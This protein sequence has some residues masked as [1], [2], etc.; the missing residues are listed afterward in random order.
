[1]K[2]FYEVLRV[3]TNASQEQIKR[4]FI[5][6]VS[7]YHPDVYKGDKLYA[8]RYTA[9]ITEAYSVL[10]DP[11]KRL[12]Y[13]LRHN[14]NQKP[15]RSQL[16]REDNEIRKEK[17]EE[18]RMSRKNYEQQMSMRYFKNTERKKQ[19]K[20]SLLFKLLTSKLFYCLL[21]VVGLECLIVLLVYSR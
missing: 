2:N 5:S 6:L 4:A 13:D 8:E 12:D 11:D 7:Q 10:K 3:R 18:K 15:S 19:K 1:M 16:R 14:I 17:M 9:I 20:K 21:F